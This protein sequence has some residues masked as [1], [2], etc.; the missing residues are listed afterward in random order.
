M[1]EEKT[2]LK[3]IIKFRKQKLK[4]LRQ[5]GVDPFPHVF[6]PELTSGKILNNFEQFE[7]QT[8]TAAGRIMSI[9][10]MGKACFIHIQDLNG[11]IQLYLKN[12][13]LPLRRATPRSATSL[14][15]SGS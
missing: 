3:Q 1:S 5:N 14:D 15:W 12:D 9:R 11:K 2:S 13:S 4:E 6:R 7:N 10:K 8:V